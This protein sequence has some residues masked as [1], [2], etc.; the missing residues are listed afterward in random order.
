LVLQGLPLVLH[1]PV[2][3]WA[4]FASPKQASAIPAKPAPNRFSACRRVTDW[5]QSLGQLI[6]FVIHTFLLV[7][8]VSVIVGCS[9]IFQ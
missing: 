9:L 4:P 3:A 7:F 8:V 1:P 6:E 5:G 2:S